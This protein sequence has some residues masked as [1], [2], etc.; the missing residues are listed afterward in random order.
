M[1]DIGSY[2]EVVE[3]HLPDGKK[4]FLVFTCG[5]MSSGYTS[6]AK[7]IAKTK[8]CTVIGEYGCLG[9]DTYGPFK[10]MGGIS[11]GHP[12]ANEIADAVKFYGDLKL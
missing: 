9:F 10:L 7:S 11:K 12:D 3:E 6:T 5:S 8:N 1:A 4:V 2:E